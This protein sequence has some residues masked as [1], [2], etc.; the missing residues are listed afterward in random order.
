VISRAR[1]APKAGREP[2]ATD[3]IAR[4]YVD[5]P[6]PHLDRLFDYQVPTTLDADVRAGSRVRVRFAG[7]LVDAYVIERSTSTEHEGKLAFLERAVGSEP[8]LTAETA[9]LFRAIADRFAGNFVDVVRLGVPA[10]HAA[11]ES[12][13]PRPPGPLPEPLPD[14]LPD[15]GL[16]RYRAGAAFL[17][18]VREQRPAR[19]VWSAVPGEDWPAR[20][21]ETARAALDVGRGTIAVVPDVRDLDRLDAAMRVALGE[22]RHVALAADLGPAERYRRWLAVRRG[23]VQV[24]IGTRAAAY[25]PVS[26]LGLLAVWDDGDDLHAEPRAPYP[27]TRDVLALRSAHTG[28]AL[29]VGGFARTAEAQLLVESGWAHDLVADR[30]VLRAAAPQVRPVAD[31][32]ELARDPAA[33][34]ARLPSLAWRTTR[35]ALQAGHPVLVQVPRGGYVPALACANDRTPARCS[36]CAGPLAASSGR[37]VPSCRWCGRPAGDWQC[38]ACG[39]HRLRAVV[40][41]AGRTAEELGRAFPGVAVR[42]SGGDHVLAEVADEPAVVVA[43]PGA[44]P[45]CPGGYGAA[46]LLDGWAL[47]SRADLRA[48]EETL[49]RWANA[50]ALVRADGTVVVGADAGVPAVQ[51]LVRWDPA[52]AASRELAERA[53]LGFPPACRMASLTGAVS[54]VAELLAAAELPEGAQVVGPVPAGDDAERVLV[55]VPRALGAELARRLKAA[56]AG[57]SARR[58]AEPVRIQLD[59]HELI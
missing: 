27:N 17:A 58:S 6:L 31:D 38:P 37:A 24:V 51:A 52:G 30:D 15:P 55:R 47:L 4:L 10:R 14:P 29:L 42:T 41:G 56:A 13:A 32:V 53:E 39:A 21:A 57:R 25:A 49:R 50:A 28:A 40:V 59:P 12:A 18:A 34:A 26:D 45:V 23:D 46:L 43:T 22:G 8:V 35:D 1:A 5:V 3:P 33:A 48:A 9:A 7:R 36:A 54:A 11:A 19:A 2:A 16:H 20:L 44:E